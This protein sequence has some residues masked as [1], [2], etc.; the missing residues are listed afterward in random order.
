MSTGEQIWHV[1]END[2]PIGVIDRDES[3]RIGA[4]YRMARVSVESEDGDILVQKRQPAKKS[5]PNCWDTSVGGNVDYGESYEDAARREAAEEIGL[6]VDKLE[7][8]AYFY[9]EATDLNG[10]KM[11]R[12]TKLY[13][14][15][16]DKATAF[17]PQPEEVSEVRW[18]SKREL[19]ELARREGL[20]D[21]LQLV[22]EH[23]YD[24]SDESH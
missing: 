19:L 6:K 5:Y 12:F 15:L 24:V 17:T 1:D 9:G 10:K 3:R 11:N 22:I 8:V 7:E 2:V 20:T 4:R 13:R 14:A 18:V 23:Y 21:G 16:V